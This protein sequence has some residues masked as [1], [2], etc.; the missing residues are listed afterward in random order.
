LTNELAS[1][2][3]IYNAD[4]IFGSNVEIASGAINQAIRLIKNNEV[5]RVCTLGFN[6]FKSLQIPAPEFSWIKKS[7]DACYFTWLFIKSEIHDRFCVLELDIYIAGKIKN[8]RYPNKHDFIYNKLELDAYPVDNKERLS[9]IEGFFDRAPMTLKTKL[10][11]MRQIRNKWDEIYH[12]SVNFPLSPKSKKKCDWA[13][14]YIQKDRSRMNTRRK[15]R[16][17]HYTGETNPASFTNSNMLSMLRPTGF[18][19]KY[20]AVKFYF[21][22]MYLSLRDELFIQRF[23]KAWQVHQYRAA[24]DT[25]ERKASLRVRV[26]NKKTAPRPVSVPTTATTLT[27]LAAISNMSFT[28]EMDVYRQYAPVNEITAQAEKECQTRNTKTLH[29]TPAD[30]SSDGQ[31]MHIP[32]GE[33]L[34]R[35]GKLTRDDKHPVSLSE[36]SLSSTS[37]RI[38]TMLQKAMLEGDKG[39]N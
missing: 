28:P 25:R 24:S 5:K 33:V 34:K 12:L 1:I 29:D 21:L 31:V 27:E 38:R 8:G 20:M 15:D 19:E 13:W 4:D 26:K 7:S 17:G 2:K 9:A 11:L 6:D 10:N 36:N 23:K 3:S 37:K 22:F 39:K 14:E 16:N 35:M 18:F 30:N 32:I